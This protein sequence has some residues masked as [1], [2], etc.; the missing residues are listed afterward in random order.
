MFRNSVPTNKYKY[1]VVKYDI[2]GDNVTDLV[3]ASDKLSELV[4]DKPIIT[5]SYLMEF[6][7]K[8][9]CHV[10]PT[11]IFNIEALHLRMNGQIHLQRLVLNML[12]FRQSPL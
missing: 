5:S 3:P 10:L 12:I 8:G 7:K 4:T 9:K 11:T 6:T 1:T 2:V